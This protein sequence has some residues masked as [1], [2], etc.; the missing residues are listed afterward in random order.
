MIEFILSAPFVLSTIC[1]IAVIM[2]VL[3]EYEENG[4]ATTLF[5]VGTALTIWA[6]KS[7]I[8][9][10]VST[11]TMYTLYFG[12]TYVIAG[13]VWSILKWKIY[14]GKHT[15]N[16]NSIKKMFIEEVGDIK[17]NWSGWIAQ[18]RDKY[19]GKGIDETQTPEKIIKKILPQVNNKKALII[20]WISYWPMSLGAT[21]L[22]NPFKKFFEWIYKMVSGIY[23]KM[24]NSAA[25][26]MLVGF[27]KSEVIDVAKVEKEGKK[28]LK[29]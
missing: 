17:G 20:S 9:N 23:D 8:W 18:L 10:F 25:K 16:F 12:F 1:I 26:D 11:N 29:G 2:A 6:Y 28:I 21:I 5:S 27:E 24:R 3:L 22:N 4:W 19:W 13:L 7:V 14:I 15:E